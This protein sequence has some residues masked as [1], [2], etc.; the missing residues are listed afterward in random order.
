MSGVWGKTFSGAHVWASQTSLVVTSQVQGDFRD[1]E[2]PAS[3]AGGWLLE[4]DVQTFMY[5]EQSSESSKIWFLFV[6]GQTIGLF[7]ARH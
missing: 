1:V 5:H 2:K 6:L 4:T 7:P 3:L